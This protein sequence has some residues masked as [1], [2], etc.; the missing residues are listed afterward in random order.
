MLSAE[1]AR[2]IILENVGAVGLEKLPLPCCLRRVLGE[3]IVSGVDIPPLDNSAMDGYAV[4][5][6]DVKSASPNHP[7]LLEVVEE[8]PAG[9]V[10]TRSL[11][12]KEAIRIMTGAPIPSGAEGVV[13]V[14]ETEKDGGQVRVFRGIRPGENIRCR[15][16]DLQKGMRVLGPGTLLG[17]AEI[18]VL[19][20]LNRATLL[21]HRRPRVAVLATGDELIEVGQE[22][23][24]GKI[25]SSNTYSLTAQVRQCGGIPID[26]GIARDELTALKG[27]LE[28]GCEA[29][30]LISSGGV[31]MGDYDLVKEALTQMNGEVKFWRLAIK[32]GMPTAF[33]LLKGKPFFGLPGNPVSSMVCFE[34]FAR[35]ALLKLGGHSH[36]SR[37]AIQAITEEEIVK[38]PGRRHFLRVMLERREGDVYA[39]ITGD[40]GSGILTSLSSAHGLA[41]IPEEVSRIKAGERVKVLL[42]DKAWEVLEEERG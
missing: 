15:G 36:L 41:V 24:P 32:P 17:P 19:A 22:M 13:M 11:K 40:Q 9:K 39:R 29:D 18:G 21:V 33:G 20:S 7:A 42:L 23:S 16:E 2:R 6:A 26:L 25:V 5:V 1:E 28:E 37:P 34:L 14:E 30:L 12:E 27:K 4:R 38:K 8:L 31:S 35:P 3:E 10:S